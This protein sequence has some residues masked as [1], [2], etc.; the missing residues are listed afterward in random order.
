M[1]KNYGHKDFSFV[2]WFNDCEST[3]GLSADESKL[4]FIDIFLLVPGTP[5]FSFTFNAICF[6]F[7]M[8]SM[9][10]GW[11]FRTS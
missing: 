6:N 5:S 8:S 10:V 11:S 9:I 7:G 2:G 1:Q 3:L 4:N